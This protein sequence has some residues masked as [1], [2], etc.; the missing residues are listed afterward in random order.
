MQYESVFEMMNMAFYR[1]S[2]RSGLF[3]TVI[4]FSP[5]FMYVSISL[6]QRYLTRVIFKSFVMKTVHYKFNQSH[7]SIDHVITIL[8]HPSISFFSSSIIRHENC[9]L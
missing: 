7:D 4:S 9:T 8:H 6:T 1:V 5:L 3:N 2:Y